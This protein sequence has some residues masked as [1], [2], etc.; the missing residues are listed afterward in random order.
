MAHK[1]YK[2]CFVVDHAYQP[3]LGVHVLSA[4]EHKLVRHWQVKISNEHVPL[5]ATDLA[6]AYNDY[7]IHHQVSD[8]M[9]H[10]RMGYML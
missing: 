3:H 10:E 2:S 4:H 7:G 6:I 9:Q 8:I 5:H 1:H